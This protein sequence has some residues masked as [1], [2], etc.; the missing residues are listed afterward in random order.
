MRPGR[1]AK[2]PGRAQEG[3]VEAQ[4]VGGKGRFQEVTEASE[5]SRGAGRQ[6]R[7]QEAGGGEESG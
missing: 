5:Q 3:G 4:G 2:V 6:R 7:G 1:G